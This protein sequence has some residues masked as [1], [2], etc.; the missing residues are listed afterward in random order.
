MGCMMEQDYRR[1]WLLRAMATGV[2]LSAP[3][4]AALA[5][6][7]RCNSLSALGCVKSRRGRGQD[8]LRSPRVPFPSLSD[9]LPDNV[10]E[11]STEYVMRYALCV[12]RCAFCVVRCAFDSYR[13]DR[14]SLFI[15]YCFPCPLLMFPSSLE[16]RTPRCSIRACGSH[17]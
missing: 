9:P 15:L 2:Y 16:P 7:Y 6:R 5:K 1:S 4:A 8:Q 10:S 13:I 3:G 17:R 14:K 11:L 12:M